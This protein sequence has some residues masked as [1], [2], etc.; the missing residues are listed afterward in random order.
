[1]RGLITPPSKSSS[2]A[3]RLER[4]VRSSCP[5]QKSNSK[6]ASVSIGWCLN[7]GVPGFS[8]QLKGIAA[9]EKVS[10]RWWKEEEGLVGALKKG[11][12]W[13]CGG[14]EGGVRKG[15]VEVLSKLKSTGGEGFITSM[16]VTVGWKF[17]MPKLEGER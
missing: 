11:V 14:E 2:A 13:W 16:S 12:K 1:M 17:E 8:S 5:L 9:E 3:E 10:R 15:E 6:S 7:L 4:E